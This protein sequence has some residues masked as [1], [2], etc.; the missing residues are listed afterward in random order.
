[1]RKKEDE[2]FQSLKGKEFCTV[3]NM[4]FEDHIKSF[5]LITGTI[6]VKEMVAGVYG[7]FTH[8][9]GL[10]EGPLSVEPNILRLDL[11]TRFYFPFLF[12]SPPSSSVSS[13]GPRI[14]ASFDLQPL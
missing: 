2:E 9:V 8:G 13:F 3:S 4:C 11:A 6:S 5:T 14:S 12:S 1:M 7:G 10:G